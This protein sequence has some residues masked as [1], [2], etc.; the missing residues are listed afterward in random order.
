MPEALACIG[1]EQAAER[2]EQP[3]VVPSVRQTRRRRLASGTTQGGPSVDTTNQAIIPSA[4]AGRA[5]SLK[6]KVAVVF[7]AGGRSR[8]RLG[9]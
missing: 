5:L 6:D 9:Q 2:R 3:L 4:D 1:S 7:G 8:R